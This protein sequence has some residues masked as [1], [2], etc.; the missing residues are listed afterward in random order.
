M[1]TIVDHLGVNTTHGPA[2][3]EV[4]G[5]VS[6]RGSLEVD[7]IKVDL[8]SIL[9]RLAALESLP[10]AKALKTEEKGLPEYDEPDAIEAQ[11]KLTELLGGKETQNDSMEES[12]TDQPDPEDDS[13][14]EQVDGSEQPVKEEVKPKGKFPP[15]K[16]KS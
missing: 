1:K 14:P 7:G 2:G 12:E 6:I 11:E 8:R 15:G 3:L 13:S 9:D 5:Y 4:D 16:K 10:G